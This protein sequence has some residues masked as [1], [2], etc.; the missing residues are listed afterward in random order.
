MLSGHASPSVGSGL[1]IFGEPAQPRPKSQGKP[2]LLLHG[3]PCGS[4]PVQTCVVELQNASM[5]Q[6]EP[7]SMVVHGAPIGCPPMSGGMSPMHVPMQQA[8][9]HAG[10]SHCCEMH[11]RSSAHT[12]PP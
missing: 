12:P 11:S 1:Q 10:T 5:M 3:L 7:N 9:G 8:S 2:S 4:K 6:S